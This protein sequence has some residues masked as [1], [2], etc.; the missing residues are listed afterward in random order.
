MLAADDAL[1]LPGERADEPKRRQAVAR[2]VQGRCDVSEFETL[3]AR[4]DVGPPYNH[5]GT[6]AVGSAWLAFY[7]TIAIHHLMASG[8][9]VELASPYR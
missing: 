4:P 7:A 1:P 3:E 8:H 2:S 6:I 9:C 5:T